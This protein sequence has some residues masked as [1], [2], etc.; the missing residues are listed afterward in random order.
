MW[1]VRELSILLCKHMQIAQVW[2]SLYPPNLQ[3]NNLFSNMK[4]VESEIWNYVIHA[5]LERS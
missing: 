5:E 4:R 1:A 3:F 2:T